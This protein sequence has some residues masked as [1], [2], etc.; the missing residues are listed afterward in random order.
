MSALLPSSTTLEALTPREREVATLVAQ[1][2]LHKQVAHELGISTET[3]AVHVYSAA[4]K[5]PGPGLPTRKIVR[6]HHLFASSDTP[7]AA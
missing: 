7:E 6:L 1:G 2:L 4:Q 5:L 3:V